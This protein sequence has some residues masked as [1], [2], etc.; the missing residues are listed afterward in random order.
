MAKQ[1]GAISFA[2]RDAETGLL[3]DIVA[4]VMAASCVVWDREE[5][6]EQPAIRLMLLPDGMDDE[7]DN[8]KEQYWSAGNLERIVPSEDEEF[9]VPAE[10]KNAAGLSKASNA[11][12]LMNSLEQ[13]SFDM[14]KL[15]NGISGLVG[16]KAHWLRIKTGRKND[17][18]EALE[19]LAVTKVFSDKGGKTAKPGQGKTTAAVTKKTTKAEPEEEE[20]EEEQEVEEQEFDAAAIA[21]ELV[22]EVVG[23]A[24]GKMLIA[25]LFNAVFKKVQARPKEERKAILEQVQDGDFIKAG[26]DGAWEVKGKEV[27]VG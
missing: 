10:G 14:S 19:A 8:Y 11:Y 15:E 20:Q 25:K 18:G 1:K 5:Y 2:P 21:S 24:G 3:N 27:V 16:M 17:A 7:E 22:V 26:G 6:G 13:A 4:T 23:E 9:F 12:V